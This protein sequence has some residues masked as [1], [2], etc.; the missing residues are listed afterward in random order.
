MHTGEGVQK[1][2][3]PFTFDEMNKIL[4]YVG[5]HLW[6]PMKQGELKTDDWK[7]KATI[8]W[9]RIG[10]KNSKKP[11]PYFELVLSPDPQHLSLKYVSRKGHTTHLIKDTKIVKDDY[12]EYDEKGTKITTRNLS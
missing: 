11:E 4:G 2:T 9:R 7:L 3:R 5:L 8:E 6:V 1:D 12:R 10:G